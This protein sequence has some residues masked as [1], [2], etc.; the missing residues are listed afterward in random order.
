MQQHDVERIARQALRE[1]GAPDGALYVMPDT[2]P[3]RWRVVLETTPVPIT[4]RIRAGRGTSAQH[5]RD[6]IFEQFQGR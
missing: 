1:L 4:M 2:E 6:Q 3:D 5:V